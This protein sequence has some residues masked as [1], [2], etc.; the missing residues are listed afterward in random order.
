MEL[1]AEPLK[2][3]STVCT[4]MLYEEVCDSPTTSMN[5][6][7]WALPMSGTMRRPSECDSEDMVLSE[8][9]T[10]Y[11]NAPNTEAGRFQEIFN[12]SPCQLLEKIG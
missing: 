2:E 5:V 12:K 9:P 11:V 8:I 6:R 7:V 10:L 1:N 3:A 4:E